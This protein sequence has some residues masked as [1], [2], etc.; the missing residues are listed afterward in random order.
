MIFDD[1]ESST[2]DGQNLLINAYCTDLSDIV[3][4]LYDGSSIF[5]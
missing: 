3:K 5:P 2:A 4:I 1:F